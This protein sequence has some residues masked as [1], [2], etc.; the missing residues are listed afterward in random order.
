MSALPTLDS[1]SLHMFKYSYTNDLTDHFNSICLFSLNIIVHHVCRCNSSAIITLWMDIIMDLA[2][3]VWLTFRS[4]CLYT[5]ASSSPRFLSIHRCQLEVTMET[6]MVMRR[7][8]EEQSSQM[9]H[10]MQLSSEIKK[11]TFT[12]RC[13]HDYWH[14]AG[15]SSTTLSILSL[16][17]NAVVKG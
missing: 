1:K 16:T 14:T 2:H 9:S 4:H 12:S 17:V 3:S 15:H 10:S 5:S 7:E 8:K 13:K 11:K 6:R